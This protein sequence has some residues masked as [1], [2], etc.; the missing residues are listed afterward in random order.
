LSCSNCSF[1]L[2]FIFEFL[3][4]LLYFL[5]SSLF[6]HYLLFII[7]IL[8]FFFYSSF[9]LL[10]FPFFLVF[11]LSLLLS[12]CTPPLSSLHTAYSSPFTI[13]YSS[14]LPTRTPYPSFY[15]SSSSFY[16][17]CS[18]LRSTTARSDTESATPCHIAPCSPL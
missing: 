5:H 6:Y 3:F 15:Y 4:I 12:V 17:H 14:F 16:F 10:I 13:F 18:V 2:S 11:I 9:F 7:Q 1:F 8:S